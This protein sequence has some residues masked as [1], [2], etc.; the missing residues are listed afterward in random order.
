MTFSSVLK[1]MICVGTNFLRPPKAKE[2]FHSVFTG[3]GGPMDL[4]EQDLII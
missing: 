1:L 4:S 2:N 3:V